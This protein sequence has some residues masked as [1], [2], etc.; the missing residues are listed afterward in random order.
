MCWWQVETQLDYCSKSFPERIDYVLSDVLHNIH[1][2]SPQ[3]Q[4]R[5]Q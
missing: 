1:K 5:L 4:P 2:S 3:R